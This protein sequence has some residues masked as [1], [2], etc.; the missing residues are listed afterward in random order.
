MRAPEILSC[1]RHSWVANRPLHVSF[2]CVLFAHSV[3][4]YSAPESFTRVAPE[5]FVR[6]E[7]GDAIAKSPILTP[8]SS[9]RRCRHDDDD[10][11]SAQQ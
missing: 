11:D 3:A 1:N 10:G 8:L 4:K 2:S 9:T 5:N 6:T 7:S